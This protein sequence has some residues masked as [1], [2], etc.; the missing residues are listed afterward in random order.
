MTAIDEPTQFTSAS[1]QDAIGH[2]AREAQ[3]WR[4][5]PRAVTR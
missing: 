1:F 2:F 5:F 3:R 4:R